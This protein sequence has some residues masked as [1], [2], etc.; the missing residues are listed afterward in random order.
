[1]RHWLVLGAIYVLAAALV[2]PTS[3]F[4]SQ[5]AEPATAAQAVTEEAAPPA[6][7]AEQPPVAVEQ[8]GVEAQAAPPVEAPPAEAPAAEPAPAAPEAASAAAAQETPAKPKEVQDLGDEADQPVAKAAAT[9]NV[10]I[11]DFEFTPATITVI[12][13]DTVIW[14]NDG[15]TGHSATAVDGSFDT[16]IFPA[17]ENREVTFDDPGT[18]AYICTPHPNMEGTVVV[19][20][21]GSNPEEQE[22]DAALENAEEVE[23]EV[24][25]EDTLPVTGGEVQAL[26][27][28]GLLMLALGA[29]I[30]FRA[31]RQT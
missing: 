14:T 19:E 4:A 22:E 24:L 16:G 23:D 1:M 11:T 28:L 15:P 5:D 12:Q 31:R 26:I 2:L 30:E 6:A 20:A 17:G 21:A 9:S 13:G 18:F 27:I 29:A 25:A 3:L 8:A 7:P 10:V